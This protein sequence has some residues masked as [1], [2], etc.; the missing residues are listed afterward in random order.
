MKKLGLAAL[1]LTGAVGQAR[2]VEYI[3]IYADAAGLDCEIA[4]PGGSVFKTF[5]IV[6]TT[7]VQPA[8]GS[9]WRLEWDPGM[10]MVYVG[11]DS[12][13]YFKVGNA[14]DGASINY[15]PCATGTLKIDTV[16]M[17]SYGTSTPCSHLSLG[18][19]PTQGRVVIYCNF[20]SIP[21]VVGNG[22]VNGDQTCPC[23]LATEETTWSKVK[24]LYR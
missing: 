22:I 6:H 7:S 1:L 23:T 16:T 9:A 15:A 20:I 18:P 19:H 17:L 24:A 8:V 5:H 4:D 14:L 13:P 11:D 2:P 12:S 10:S 3:G 21:F